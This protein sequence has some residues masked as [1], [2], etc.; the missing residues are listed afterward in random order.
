MFGMCA[1][2]MDAPVQLA[3]R[4]LV[5]QAMT[6]MMTDDV[7]LTDIVNTDGFQLPLQHFLSGVCE[8]CSWGGV[9]A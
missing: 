7:I 8:C 1:E 2:D 5:A 3:F 4:E 9:G 6:N